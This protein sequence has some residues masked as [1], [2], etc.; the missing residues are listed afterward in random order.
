MGALGSIGS[1][2]SGKLYSFLLL[3]IIVCFVF[4]K[5]VGSKLQ[6]LRVKCY[7]NNIQE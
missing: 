1:L 4:T 2:R 3:F 7:I 6:R 5:I